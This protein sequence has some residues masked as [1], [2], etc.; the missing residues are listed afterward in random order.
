M[1][2][3]AIKKISVA[4]GLFAFTLIFFGSWIYE[5]RIWSSFIRGLEGFALFSLLAW[6][7]L[8]AWAALNSEESPEKDPNKDKGVNL[9]QTA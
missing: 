8:R 5:A 1:S 3:T 4:A 2:R 7:V 9:D 6:L